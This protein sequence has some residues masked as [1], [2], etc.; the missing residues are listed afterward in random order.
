MILSSISPPRAGRPGAQSDSR[1]TP[2]HH[3]LPRATGRA[4]RRRSR[5]RLAQRPVQ[6][7]GQVTSQGHLGYVPASPE[8]Q[9]LIL[10]PQFGIKLRRAV[11]SSHK[12]QTKLFIPLFADVSQ[13]LVTA[14]GILAR[15]QPQIT[16]QL[17]AVRKTL[18]RTY[19]QHEGQSGHRPHALVLHQLDRLR[20]ALGLRLHRLIEL[21]DPRPQTVQQLQQLL[22][23]LARPGAQAQPFELRSAPRAPQLLLPAHAL[24]HGQEVQLVPHRGLHPHQLVAVLQ[25]LPHVALLRRRHPDAREA[26]RQQQIQQVL[27]VPRVGLL[28]PHGSGPNLGRVS[29]PQLVAQFRHQALEPLRVARRLHPDQRW[30]R[31]TGIKR[32]RFSVLMFQ[33]AR[34]PLAGVGLYHGDKLVARMQITSDNRHVRLLS[35]QPWSWTTN[36]VYRSKGADAVME[37]DMVLA[38]HA[39][40]YERLADASGFPYIVNGLGGE[41][42]AGFGS[43]LPSGVTSVVRYNSDFGAMLVTANT[44][45]IT[46]QFYSAGGNL[47]DTYSQAKNCSGT[48]GSPLAS[49]SPTSLAFP[50][51]TVGTASGAQAVTLSNSGSAALSITSI[52]VT[53][54]N[55]GDFGQTNN[56]GSSLAAGSSCAINVTFTPTATGTRSGTLTVTD[57]ASNSPQTVSLTGTGATGT[58]SGPAFVQGQNNIDVSGAAFTSF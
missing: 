5:A 8:N 18:D 54:T 6:T 23:P 45:G 35:R 29:D 47:I 17:A 27:G 38:G 33:P 37:S 20:T 43:T 41:D 14:A 28:P 30:L 1:W 12:K 25:Q 10:A 49:F 36:Q 53:G 21:G 16:D 48:G 13:R 4:N 34:Y 32:P 50:S 24:A 26:F 11:A 15:V 56:C 39:H 19:G 3:A 7:H 55:S 51:Q 9:T 42:I 40:V 31:Q 46:Y 57:N 22:P 2:V 52:A 44:S 58:G